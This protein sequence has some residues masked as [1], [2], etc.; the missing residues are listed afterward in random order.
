MVRVGVVV[1]YV[2]RA[3][4]DVLDVDVNVA[5]KNLVHSILH[6]MIGAVQQNLKYQAHHQFVHHVVV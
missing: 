5:P 6:F 1:L 2:H 4:E 3:A